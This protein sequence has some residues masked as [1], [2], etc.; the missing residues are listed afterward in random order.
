MK[1]KTTKKIIGYTTVDSGQLIIVDP[2]YLGEWKDGE[3]DDLTSHYGKACE[4]TLNKNQGGKVLVSNIAGMGV[5]VS[6]GWGDGNFPVT[7]IYKDGRVK[8]VRVKFF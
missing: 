7:A 5:A 2:C 4:Q 3:S 1:N 8:E 6:T